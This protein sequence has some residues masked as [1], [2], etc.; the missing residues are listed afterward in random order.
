MR[1][2][3]EQEVIKRKKDKDLLGLS[4]QIISKKFAT[5]SETQNSNLIPQSISNNLETILT[6]R[7]L[8]SIEVPSRLKSSIRLMEV[9]TS[10]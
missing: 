9:D 7:I 4:L 1:N 8:R 6:M 10:I 3:K 2:L 5:C